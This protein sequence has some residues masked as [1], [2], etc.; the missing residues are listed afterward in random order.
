VDT[1][2]EWRA[3]TGTHLVQL[4]WR[5]TLSTNTPR[6]EPTKAR[7]EGIRFE[8]TFDSPPLIKLAQATSDPTRIACQR[9]YPALHF[10]LAVEAHGPQF[11]NPCD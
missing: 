5:A 10:L 8:H 4:E 3:E 6:A 7:A 1:T 9:P 2:L 11:Y